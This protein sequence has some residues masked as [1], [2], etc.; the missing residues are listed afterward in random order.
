MPSSAKIT[1]LWLVALIPF[2]QAQPGA[3]GTV[4]SPIAPSL[5]NPTPDGSTAPSADLGN[6]TV[7][8]QLEEARSEIVPSLGATA[9]TV[10]KEQIDAEP[11]GANAPFNQILLRTPGM[12]QDSLGQLHLRGEHANLQYRINDVLLPEGITG[13]GQEL[14]PRF[15]DSLQLITG[16]L[17]AQYGFRTAGIVDIQTKS[18]AFAQG[19]EASLEVGSYDTWRPSF[20]Y[21]GADGKFNYYFDGSFDQNDIGIENPT[22]SSMPIHDRTNQIRGFTYLSYILSDTSQLSAMAG[23]SYGNF[24]IPDSPGLPAGLAP[25]GTQWVPGSFNSATLDEN[26]TEQNDYGILAYQ[27]STGNLNL[28]LAAFGRYSSVRFSPDPVGDLFFDG[29]AGSVDR[30]IYSTGLQNDLSYRLNDTHTLRAGWTVLEEVA[31]TDSTTT[32]FPT[33]GAGNP[34][35]PAETISQS[36]TIDAQFYGLYLQDEWKVTPK[37]TINYGFRA[38]FYA[39]TVREGQISP[40]INLIYKVDQATTLH[41]GYARYFTPPPLES[42]NGASVAAFTGTSNAPEVTTNDPVRSERSH[43]FDAGITHKLT[44]A[45]QVGLD[46]YFKI[47]KNQLDDGFFGQTLIPSAFNYANGR[48]YGIELTTNYTNGGFSTYANAAYSVARGETITSAQFLFGADSLSYIQNNWVNLD[49]DQTVTA[50]AGVAYT[51][52]HEMGNTRIFL[53]AL[54]GS[55]LRKDEEVSG[56]GTIPNGARVPTYWTLNAG[57]EQGFKTDSGLL[58]KAR[59]EGTNL[60]DKVYQLRNGSGIGVNAPQ[61]GMRLGIFGTLSCSF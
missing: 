30:R 34:T 56:G 57:I 10:D 59:L 48:I 14:D 38:D 5:Q 41:A 24:Q 45:W 33:D 26:Q 19:G 27:K 16:S 22:P 9:Y 47:A 31:P 15:V 37:L 23:T 13:F 1:A 43:Y 29:V 25:N 42:V 32:V 12:A 51:W 4:A 60:L 53:D 8:G 40:R 58:F 49:H 55:G 46:G 20:E 50:S 54:A 2:A 6:I 44:P 36:N 18:G 39:S 61:Y 17:P 3:T 11:Q 52:K 35:G 21:G 7:I 28:Q